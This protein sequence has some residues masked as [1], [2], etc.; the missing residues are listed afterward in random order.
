MERPTLDEVPSRGGGEN[1]TP[2]TPGRSMSAPVTYP[3]NRDMST[4][5]VMAPTAT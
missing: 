1:P 3:D 5:N 4:R 2:E